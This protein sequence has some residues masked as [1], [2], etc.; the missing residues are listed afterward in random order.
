[1]KEYKFWESWFGKGPL[2]EK[3]DRYDKEVWGT[4]EKNR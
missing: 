1:M 2:T 3:L 4:I